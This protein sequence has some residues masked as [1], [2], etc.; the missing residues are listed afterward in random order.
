MSEN[1]DKQKEMPMTCTEETIEK[2]GALHQD[3]GPLVLPSRRGGWYRIQVPARIDTVGP[4]CAFLTV[5]AERHGLTGDEIRC[6]EIAVYETCLNV[7]E[8]AYGFDPTARLTIRISFGGEKLTLSFTDTGKGIDPET[9]PPPDVANPLV[10]L[11][12]RGF[13]LEMIRNSVDVVRFRVTPRG[14][15]NLLLIKNLVGACAG[16]GETDGL[17]RRGGE[18]E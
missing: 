2:F 14:E 1:T 7:I 3:F 12:G 16:E 10:R 13:G 11:Q 15:N 4:L 5:L 17:S 8:P 6:A 9:I 18:K